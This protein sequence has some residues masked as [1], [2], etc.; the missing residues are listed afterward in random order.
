MA[1]QEQ[2]SDLQPKVDTSPRDVAMGG[3]SILDDPDFGSLKASRRRQASRME[4][5][6]QVHANKKDQRLY[7]AAYRH[8]VK[9][10]N[11]S[12][13]LR[14]IGA[15]E[16]LGMR[17]SG[18][19]MAGEQQQIASDQI[20]ARRTF[21]EGFGTTTPDEVALQQD[22]MRRFA[23][24]Q[25]IP[26]NEP[27]LVE[28]QGNQ[29]PT[30]TPDPAAG[31]LSDYV[32]PAEDPASGSAGIPAVNPEFEGNQAQGGVLVAVGSPNQGYMDLKKRIND[33]YAANP[34]ITTARDR[35][36]L[37]N[38]VLGRV[39]KTDGG[40]DVGNY[41]ATGKMLQGRRDAREQA[42]LDA[43][44]QKRFDSFF[45]EEDT[46]SNKRRSSLAQIK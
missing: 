3:G 18:I 28:F 37:L 40:G 29:V 27:G 10:G 19:R 5:N 13:A 1:L 12:D 36:M 33:I 31:Q 17:E 20:K 21:E 42:R 2:F 6:Q 4:L 34:T 26:T 38:S 43:E 8:A 15:R 39:G 23:E 16:E 32:P 41:K 7:R 30:G 14:L 25:G 22:L 11:T 45:S 44:D 35:Q 46:P 24:A 9:S